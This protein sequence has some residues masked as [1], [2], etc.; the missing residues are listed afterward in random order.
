MMTDINHESALD[1]R[2]RQIED[3]ATQWFTR[4]RSDCCT[5]EDISGHEAWL[6]ES[7]MHEKVYLQL[8]A[9][10][11]LAGDFADKPEVVTARKQDRLPSSPRVTELQQCKRR[12]KTREIRRY[13]TGRA[14]FPFAL[15]AAVVVVIL[16]AGF[17]F[18]DNWKGYSQEDYYQTAIGEKKVQQL[19]DGSMLLLDT[20]THVT[21]NFTEKQRRIVLEKGQ[22]HFDVAYDKNRPFIVEAGKGMVTALGTAFVVRKSEQ[23]VLVTLIEGRVLVTQDVS[24]FTPDL[25]ST[26]KL[27]AG[28][29][30]AYTEVGI[31]KA[32]IVNIEQATAWQQGR[33]VFDDHSLSDVIEDL[34]RYSKRKILLG[35][36]SLASIRITG[37][38]K[39][40]DNKKAIQALK[41]YFSMKVVTDSRGNLVLLPTLDSPAG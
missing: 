5:A 28:E 20:Q 27:E 9:V 38:L 10:W 15:S 3:Q 30:I 13:K 32:S 2:D 33:L 37:V 21:I 36:E 35:D 40:G 11:S 18:Y 4:M 31:S 39:P 29:Q 34:N 19:S 25:K 26:R 23:E 7:L 41:T 8:E 12:Q 1:G 24:T 14:W 17:G 22:A 6:N 16:A